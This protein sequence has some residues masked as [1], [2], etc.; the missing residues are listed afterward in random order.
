MDKLLNDPYII[1]RCIFPFLQ[2]KDLKKLIFIKQFFIFFKEATS[3][4]T[5]T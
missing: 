2:Y 1:P 5:L 4:N 3:G